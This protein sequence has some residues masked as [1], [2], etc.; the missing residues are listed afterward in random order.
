MSVQN[1]DWSLQQD[2]PIF[3]EPDSPVSSDSDPGHQLVEGYED[4]SGQAPTG[5]S[6][7]LPC[8]DINQA[9]NWPGFRTLLQQLPPQDSDVGHPSVPPLSS[10]TPSPHLVTHCEERAL[11]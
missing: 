1:S 10:S 6:L 8:L 3:R 4:T 7:G 9:S 5:S 11:V 2:S